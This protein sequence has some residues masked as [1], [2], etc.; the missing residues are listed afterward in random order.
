MRSY[1][2]NVRILKSKDENQFM[3]SDP[4]GIQIVIRSEKQT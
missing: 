1:F 3:V 4:D 2:G